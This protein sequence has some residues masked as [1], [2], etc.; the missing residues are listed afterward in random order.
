MWHSTRALIHRVEFNDCSIST[1]EFALKVNVW[2]HSANGTWYWIRIWWK[3]QVEYFQTKR[4]SSPM[5]PSNY[6]SIYFDVR[7]SDI[8]IR[9]P[10]SIKWCLFHVIDS[11]TDHKADWTNLLRNAKMYQ[12]AALRRW[13]IITPRR[14]SGDTSN[15]VRSLATVTR[16][17]GFQMDNPR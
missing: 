9:I 17:M 1:D 3:F 6:I 8:S 13:Y 4:F 14:N 2:T 10:K 7:I 16:N 12:N 15:F 5:L 11:D